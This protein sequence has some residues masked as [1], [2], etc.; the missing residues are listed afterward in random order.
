MTSMDAPPT[1]SMVSLTV[2][3]ARANLT[4]SRP[5]KFNAMNVEMI[6]ELILLLEWTAERS[7]GGKTPLRTAKAALTCEPL[8]FEARGSTSARAPTST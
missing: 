8:S 4:L 1:T 2:D 6:Q 5:D 3:G 7:A